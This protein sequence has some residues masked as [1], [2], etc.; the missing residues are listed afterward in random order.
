MD[1]LIEAVIR[2]STLRE[3]RR[4]NPFLYVAD[5]RYHNRK[6][7]RPAT[8]HDHDVA[9]ELCRLMKHDQQ[10]RR[11]FRRLKRWALKQAGPR[12]ILGNEMVM[13][14]WHDKAAH[15]LLHRAFKFFKLFES[16]RM[17]R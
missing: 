13:R 11:R 5:A 12:P 2:I 7:P 3:R 8:S 15:A 9:L 17:K 4:F 6:H 10:V 16:E 1:P 14:A